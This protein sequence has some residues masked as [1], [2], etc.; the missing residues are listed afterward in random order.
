M[1]NVPESSAHQFNHKSIRHSVDQAADIHCFEISFHMSGIF[2]KRA[3]GT[4]HMTGFH[5]MTQ[6][7]SHWSKQFAPK[8]PGALRR[9]V[10]HQQ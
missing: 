4:E 7:S 2:V 3:S 8:I 9:V 5:D 1:Y 6:V 10:T